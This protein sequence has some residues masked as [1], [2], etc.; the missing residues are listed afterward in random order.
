M[1][2]NPNQRQTLGLA[3]VKFLEHIETFLACQIYTQCT[4]GHAP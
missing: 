3:R 1:A 4:S 2:A